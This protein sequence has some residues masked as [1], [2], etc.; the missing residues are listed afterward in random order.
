[1]Q[2]YF[3]LRLDKIIIENNAL[4]I[5]LIVSTW[6][7]QIIYNAIDINTDALEIRYN[8]GMHLFLAFLVC[9][10]K[11]FPSN[12]LRVEPEPQVFGIYLSLV[13]IP[14]AF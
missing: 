7:P 11:C 1:V 6:V 14:L 8:V 10:I 13:T 4:F 3:F 9:Y 5:A 12:A 2:L